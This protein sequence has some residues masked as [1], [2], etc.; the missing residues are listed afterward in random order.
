MSEFI[1]GCKKK[2]KKVLRTEKEKKKWIREN[3]PDIS[4]VKHPKSGALQIAVEDKMLMLVGT[5]TSASRVKQEKFD[6]K[7]GAK[8][9]MQQARE[10]IR[11]STNQRVPWQDRISVLGLNVLQLAKP[12]H[13]IFF[14]ASNFWG[15]GSFG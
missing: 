14:G 5:R 6:N 15:L 11:V 9:S 8:N 10:S 12:K 7:E 13:R 2:P 4:F 1:E 3:H